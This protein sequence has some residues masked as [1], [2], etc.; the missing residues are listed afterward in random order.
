MRGIGFGT[1]TNSQASCSTH[2]LTVRGGATAGRHLLS[3][4]GANCGRVEA[5]SKSNHEQQGRAL[6]PWQT[7]GRQPCVESDICP[8][9]SPM[10]LNVELEDMLDVQGPWD[11]F[12]VNERRFGVKTTFDENLTQY[13]TALQVANVPAEIRHKVDRVASEIENEHKRNWR[14]DGDGYN[15]AATMTSMDEDEET[16]FCAVSRQQVQMQ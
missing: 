16:K 13:T 10:E 1:Q 11:Q 3:M 12:E 9:Y 4:I 2:Q 14:L 15:C 6:Q 7:L 5:A 8:G